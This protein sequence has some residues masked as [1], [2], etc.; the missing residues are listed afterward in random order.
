[1]V[2]E[3]KNKPASPQGTGFG[4]QSGKQARPQADPLD[5]E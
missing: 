2:A 4:K 3:E 1:V 5:E